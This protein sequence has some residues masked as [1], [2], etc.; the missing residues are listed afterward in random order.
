[1]RSI[2]CMLVVRNT[3]LNTWLRGVQYLGHIVRYFGR[4]VDSLGDIIMPRVNVASH[5]SDYKTFLIIMVPL[6]A[7]CSQAIGAVLL[8][9]YTVFSK[10]AHCYDVRQSTVINISDI[11]GLTLYVYTRFRSIKDLNISWFDQCV[12]IDSTRSISKDLH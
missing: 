12:V 5:K 9:L 1:M 11:K 10:C 7:W 3:I 2:N 8:F 6:T 4:Y